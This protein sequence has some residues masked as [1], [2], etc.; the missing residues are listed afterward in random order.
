ML[1]NGAEPVPA[2]TMTRSRGSSTPTVSLMVNTPA[3]TGAHVH[4]IAGLELP[5]QVGERVLRL[6]LR[7]PADVELDRAVV[8][9]RR[10]DR[11]R[12]PHRAELGLLLVVHAEHAVLAGHEPR[13]LRGHLIR[14]DA[15]QRQR[16]G[17]DRCARPAWRCTRVAWAIAA[18]L[19]QA[20]AS[21]PGAARISA[22]NSCGHEAHQPVL[23]LV[24]AQVADG[25]E[26]ELAR[27]RGVE[28]LRRV[29]D[30]RQLDASIARRA[31]A[32]RGSGCGSWRGPCWSR[33]KSS[34]SITNS[35]VAVE[36]RCRVRSAGGARSAS[37]AP[38]DRGGSTAAATRRVAELGDD[39]G[40]AG[41][42]PAARSARSARTR[43]SA[44]RTARAR[45]RVRHARRDCARRDR[46][47]GPS[48]RGRVERGCAGRSPTIS[49]A[50]T[51]SNTPSSGAV[52]AS[53]ID[54]GRGAA[55]ARAAA[56]RR[57][58]VRAR[59]SCS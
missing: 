34:R 26:V 31:R 33:S 58:R 29:A 13:P 16:V 55:D 27:E 39:R 59:R 4:A 23:D 9:G 8:L 15:E 30:L 54:P 48:P 49:F 35:I 21:T 11:H 5:Q 14:L 40:A 22:L 7:D 43:R 53:P 42:E 17:D 25:G 12:A 10:R 51:R 46:D 18:T 1:R 56:P 3:A 36:A 52:S 50:I 6:R 47:R 24:P 2:A 19:A 57:A 37:T 41:R 28:Q 45:R 38:D 32:A 44:G 20:Q